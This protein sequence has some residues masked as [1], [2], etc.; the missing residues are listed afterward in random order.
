MSML[1]KYTNEELKDLIKELKKRGYD[2]KENRK[3][4]ILDQEAEKLGMPNS[5]IS[6]D[7]SNHIY[8]LADWATDNY[9]IKNPKKGG[10]ARCYR[11]QTIPADIEKEYRQILSVILTALKPYYGKLEFREKRPWLN[12][13]KQ[14]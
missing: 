11:T 9:I 8:A 4:E 6:L 14:E 3:G 7:V 12:D 2:I 13:A 5:F 1:E 10:P